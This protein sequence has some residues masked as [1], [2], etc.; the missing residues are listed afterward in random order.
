MCL[1]IDKVPGPVL[2]NTHSFHVNLNPYSKPMK[3]ALNVSIFQLRVWDTEWLSILA[4]LEKGKTWLG[5]QSWM[6]VLMGFATTP[7]QPG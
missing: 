2:S 5:P 6:L 4:K 1:S 7:T 3:W